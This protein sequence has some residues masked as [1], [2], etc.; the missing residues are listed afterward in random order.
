M[1]TYQTAALQAIVNAHYACL[2]AGGE[3]AGEEP[4]QP[5]YQLHQTFLIAARELLGSLAP[6]NELWRWVT[7]LG[8]TVAHSLLEA[9]LSSLPVRANP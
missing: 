5:A 8:E 2:L 4:G 6:A 9:P 3:L 7:D 1:N